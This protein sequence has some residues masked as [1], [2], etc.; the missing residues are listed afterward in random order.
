VTAPAFDRVLPPC[1]IV[2]PAQVAD[3]R[4]T[5]GR[6]FGVMLHYDASQS[7]AG[8]I[9]WFRSPKFTLSYH[10]A[11]TDS[12]R[13]VQILP[14]LAGTCAFH[15]GVCRQT[16]QVASANDAFYGFAVTAGEGDTVTAAQLRALVEDTALVARWH[17][18]FNAAPEMRAWWGTANVGTWLTGHNEWAIFNRRDNPKS[19][20]L[21][22]R[23][24]RKV[25]P[26]GADPDRPVLSLVRARDAVR[27][28]LETPNHPIW[29]RLDA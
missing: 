10:R 22:G 5:T 12:G 25:D 6:R 1:E 15:A 23:L 3:F 13:R 2:I 9:S 27:D 7:D 11:Y 19:P 26:I 14:K 24:G 21:W 28:L 29:A 20:K 16:E 8:A 17:Q 18:R 4:P